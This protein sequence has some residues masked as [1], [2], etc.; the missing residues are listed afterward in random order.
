MHLAS[1]TMDAYRSFAFLGA[2]N[3]V[4]Q[5]S[6]RPTKRSDSSAF[7]IV[8]PVNHII[9]LTRANP[10][11]TH[12][13]DRNSQK[14][15]QHGDE[16]ILSKTNGS[17]FFVTTAPWTQIWHTFMFAE[18]EEGPTWRCSSKHRN[19][20]SVDILGGQRHLCRDKWLAKTLH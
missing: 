20:A 12:N 15:Q 3:S 14:R 6:S 7:G 19:D 2:N 4:K 8:G 17:S 9:C 10:I 1:L 16:Q 13:N 11:T 18:L 5:S